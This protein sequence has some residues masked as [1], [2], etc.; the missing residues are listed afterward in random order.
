MSSGFDAAL[1]LIKEKYPK[2]MW[3]IYTFYASDGDN[4]S[5]DNEKAIASVKKICEVSNLVSYCELLPSTYSTT[6]YYRFVKEVSNK[7]FVPMIVKE[8]KDIWTAIKNVLSK[9]LKE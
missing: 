2:E 4:W 7:N 3:N 6:M 9:E 1:D 5:E 8:K